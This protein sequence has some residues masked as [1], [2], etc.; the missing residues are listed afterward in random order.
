[1]DVKEIGYLIKSI[2]D[3]IKF[4]ADATLKERGLTF[5]QCRVLGFLHEHGGK[6]TQKQ[7]EENFEI[8][9]P[10]VVGLVARAEKNG[11]L[12]TWFDPADGRSKLVRL[13]EKAEHMGQEM[14][15]VIRQQEAAMTHGLS[16][17]EVRELKRMLAVIYKNLS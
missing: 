5:A 17:E 16:P 13:T 15:R 8:S 4:Q 12:A 9:H 7:I 1:M 2:N 3:K 14:D 11:Y 6:A 10:T